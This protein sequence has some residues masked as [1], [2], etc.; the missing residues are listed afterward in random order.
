VAVFFRDTQQRSSLVA[1]DLNNVCVRAD[2]RRADRRRAAFRRVARGREGCVSG[3]AG[4]LM[5]PH[6]RA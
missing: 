3:D 4:T 6:H 1:G 5:T 2:R